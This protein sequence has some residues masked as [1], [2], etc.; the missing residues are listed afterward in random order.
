MR[1]AW[2]QI[3]RRQSTYVLTDA[4]PYE[5]LRDAFV[6]SWRSERLEDFEIVALLLLVLVVL[7][8]VAIKYFLH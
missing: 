5:V 4:D 3:D 8:F 1:R 6:A 7:G 2:E